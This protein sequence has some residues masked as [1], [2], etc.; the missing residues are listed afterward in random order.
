MRIISKDSE[1][2]TDIVKYAAGKD[3]TFF[4]EDTK[5]A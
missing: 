3:I 4:L 2:V 1:V 5:N